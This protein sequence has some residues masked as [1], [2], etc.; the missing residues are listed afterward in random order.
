MKT[1]SFRFVVLVLALV[2]GITL[3]QADVVNPEPTSCPNGS[4][5]S[6]GHVGPHCAPA[7]CKSDADCKNGTTC[8]EVSLCTTTETGYHRGGSY[9]V[10]FVHA[11]CSKG[12]SCSKGT[13]N[14]GMRC[15]S[16]SVTGCNQLGTV[17]GSIVLSVLPFFLL[18]ALMWLRRIIKASREP[19]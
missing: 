7:T 10:D 13:C 18:F 6:T 11:T 14:T 4:T 5:P 17:S 15:A 1:L 8:R 2:T 9:K 19:S 16:N 3:A 12:G